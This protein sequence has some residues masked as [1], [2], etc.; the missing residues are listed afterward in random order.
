MKDI[1]DIIDKVI[2]TVSDEKQ[3]AV[4]RY[5]PQLNADSIV[6]GSV[7]MTIKGGEDYVDT[8]LVG[9]FSLGSDKFQDDVH[10]RII[11]AVEKR[12]LLEVRKK[13]GITEEDAEIDA[14]VVEDDLD[15]LN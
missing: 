13:L 7:D 12:I 14:E 8:L 6:I 4:H 5:L 10:L 15:F 11:E 9:G 3:E 1:T 2:E